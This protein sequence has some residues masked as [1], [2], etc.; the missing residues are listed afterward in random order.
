[1]TD[2]TP[3][4][5]LAD[6]IVSQ[7]VVDGRP[8]KTIAPPV[9][10]PLVDVIEEPTAE[11]PTGEFFTPVAE[12]PPIHLSDREVDTLIDVGVRAWSRGCCC[13]ALLIAA[14][15]LIAGGWI[16]YETWNE[17][18]RVALIDVPDFPVSIIPQKPDVQTIPGN[19]GFTGSA[20]MTVHFTCGNQSN[21]FV[22]PAQLQIG[23]GRFFLD[24]QGV[25][26]FD[27]TVSSAN[28]V[29]APGQLG[30]V[31]GTLANGQTQSLTLTTDNFPCKGVFPL[32]LQLPTPLNLSG[33]TTTGPPLASSINGNVA[34][35]STSSGGTSGG[36]DVPW[37]LIAIGVILIGLSA[38]LKRWDPLRRDEWTW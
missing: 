7:D 2:Q 11:A 17:P 25:P 24:P 13:L 30:T 22:L 27:G 19:A 36:R 28:A 23:S 21:Q 4:V 5:G 9:I 10:V 33:S 16:G 35:D 1:M 18:S 20:P 32:M 3:I 8:G 29:N 14:I 6:S 34:I 15:I 12:T 26:P 37:L 31:T 38:G